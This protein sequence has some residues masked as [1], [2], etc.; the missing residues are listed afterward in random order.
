MKLNTLETRNK[1][2]KVN[3]KNTQNTRIMTI[4]VLKLK[5]QNEVQAITCVRQLLQSFWFIFNNSTHN[6]RRHCTLCITFKHLERL[7]LCA[8]MSLLNQGKRN[9]PTK[10]GCSKIYILPCLSTLSEHL[11]LSLEEKK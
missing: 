2:T 1:K 3:Q 6:Y 4:S 8:E 5:K 10:Q 11:V 7:L 9:R